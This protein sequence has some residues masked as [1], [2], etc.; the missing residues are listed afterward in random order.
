MKIESKTT[1]KRGGENYKRKKRKS[2]EERKQKTNW[3]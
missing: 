2:I 3:E 1:T